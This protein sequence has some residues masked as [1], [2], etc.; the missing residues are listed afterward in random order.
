MA[1]VNRRSW[2]ATRKG[3]TKPPRREQMEHDR[4][5]DLAEDLRNQVFEMLDA[6]PEMTGDIAGIVAAAVEN[7][8]TTK[9][10]T[11]LENRH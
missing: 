1:G 3:E 11:L 8:F 9:L 7:A 6:E 4:I 2:L 10:H 5:H